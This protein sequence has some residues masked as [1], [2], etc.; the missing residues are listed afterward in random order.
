MSLHEGVDRTHVMFS[1][2]MR[3]RCQL[4]SHSFTPTCG[5]N[6]AACVSVCVLMAV[7]VWSSA[8][9]R[10]SCVSGSASN[11]AS[12]LLVSSHWL[13]LNNICHCRNSRAQFV[14]QQQQQQQR[15]T[16]KNLKPL[17][18]THLFS[19]YALSFTLTQ[20]QINIFNLNFKTAQCWSSNS[21]KLR[22]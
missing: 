17:V 1:L 12:R 18:E 6:A 8:L 16:S 4:V 3:V 13:L 7:T 10:Y 2:F 20:I 19:V 15:K 9:L 22:C 5:C 21:N 14:Q 11:A